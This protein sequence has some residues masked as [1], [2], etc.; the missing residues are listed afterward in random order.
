M[1][2][3][4]GISLKTNNTEVASIIKTLNPVGGGFDK[5]STE[6]LLSTYKSI[7]SQ[8]TFS[9]TFVFKLLHFQIKLRMPL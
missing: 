7:L 1:M 8:L 4:I 5:I 9:S 3:L 2:I 6:I